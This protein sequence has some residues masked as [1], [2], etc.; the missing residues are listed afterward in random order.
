MF[1][2]ANPKTR[3]VDFVETDNIKILTFLNQS[4]TVLGKGTK[5]RTFFLSADIFAQIKTYIDEN[6]LT[7]E[8]FLFFAEDKSISITRMQA[9]RIIR[10]A[11]KRAKVDPIPSPHWFR[12][13]SATH[14]IENGAPIHFVQHSLGHAS[15]NTTGKYLHATSTAS[16]KFNG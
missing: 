2:Q 3:Q 10:I 11:A 16:K 1:I 13:S 8:E 4:M 14:A 12:H 9:F 5:V 6:E 7:D 15:I